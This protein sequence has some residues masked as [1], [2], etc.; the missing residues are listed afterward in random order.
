MA[1]KIKT[2]CHICATVTKAEQPLAVCPCCMTNLAC[3]E[4]MLQRQAL[5]CLFGNVANMKVG[6][7]GADNG[8]LFLTNQRLFAL[9]EKVTA[10]AAVGAAVGGLIGGAIAAAAGAENRQMAFIIPRGNIAGVEDAKIGLFGAI[11]LHTTDGHAFKIKLPK[12]EI[13]QWKAMLMQW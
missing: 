8:D 4:E 13:P 7:M 3:P 1:K 10:G 5:G 6:A 12:R 2:T 9:A 11:L